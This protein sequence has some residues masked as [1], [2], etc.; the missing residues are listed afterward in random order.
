MQQL[1]DIHAPFT[2]VLVCRRGVGACEVDAGLNTG[3]NAVVG[4]DQASVAVEPG[5]ATVIQRPPN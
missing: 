4:G 3:R 5:E 1:A 2:Q